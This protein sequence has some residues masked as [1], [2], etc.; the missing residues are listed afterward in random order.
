MN[1]RNAK[2]LRRLKRSSKADKR[3][4]NSFTAEQR[5]DIRRDYIERGETARQEY[6]AEKAK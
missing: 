4:F 6:K 1:Q 5:A 3:L 2:M